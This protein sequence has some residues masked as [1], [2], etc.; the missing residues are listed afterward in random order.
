M[1]CIYCGAEARYHRAV[2]SLG[3]GDVVGGVCRDCDERVRPGRGDGATA[4]DPAPAADGGSAVPATPPAHRCSVCDAPAT[5]ALAEH[6]IELSVVDG[7][8]Y[9]REGYPVAEE[10]PLVCPTHRPRGGVGDTDGGP[11]GTGE[12]GD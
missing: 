12:P 6:T 9:E 3:A 1:D 8:E 11:T 10:T 5:H 2:V 4:P 7:E